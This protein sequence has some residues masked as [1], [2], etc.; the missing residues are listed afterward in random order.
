MTSL[1]VSFVFVFFV[2][3]FFFFPVG[4]LLILKWQGL[5]SNLDQIRIP[6]FAFAVEITKLRGYMR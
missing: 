4:V 5:V 3:V 1:F 2:C 6:G